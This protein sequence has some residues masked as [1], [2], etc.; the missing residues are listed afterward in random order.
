MSVLPG[1][2][3]RRAVALTATLVGLALVGTGCSGGSDE[4]SSSTAPSPESVTVPMN[5]ALAGLDI[6]A[7]G[8]N[9]AAAAAADSDFDTALTAYDQMHSEWER[10]EGTVKATDPDAYESMETAQGLMRDGIEVDNAD[11]VEQGAVDQRDA[12]TVFI[13]ENR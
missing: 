11:R 10:V 7:E 9:A 4:S 1:S 6:V 12:I 5:D 2:R 3:S 13:D 8:G